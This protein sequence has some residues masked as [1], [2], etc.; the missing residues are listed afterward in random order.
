MGKQHIF[1]AVF[2]LTLFPAIAAADEAGT[3]IWLSPS[4]KVAEGAYL[5]DRGDTERGMKLTLE[6]LKE[7]LMLTDR[8]AA[9][10]NLCTA[11]LEL[12]RLH[13][14]IAHCTTAVQIRRSLWQGYNNRGNAYFMLGKYDA[15]ISDYNRALMI[16]PE[17]RILEY[18][19]TLAMDRKA[20]KV[21]PII[22]EWES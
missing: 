17:M 21:P 20:R 15:A 10:N 7:D 9:L 11:E 4:T 13:D 16:R 14:A 2:A 8:A 12:K 18:N 22:E 1:A 6:A 5:I 19:L 3:T